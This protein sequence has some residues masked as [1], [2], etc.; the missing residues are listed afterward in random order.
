M[1]EARRLYLRNYRAS[2]KAARRVALQVWREAHREEHNDWARE[3]NRTHAD[4]V[5]ASATKWHEAHPDYRKN[6]RDA[7]RP[8]LAALLAKYRAAKLKATPHWLTREQF[9]Q[10][11][12]FYIE[13]HCLEQADGVKRHVDHIYPLRGK[14]VSG[15]H[16]PWN[17]QILTATDNRHK[18]TKMPV[19]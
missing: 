14:T 6:Y 18:F 1:T 7:H 16:V 17:L 2:H 4:K 5:A 11:E 19:K 9:K 3:W 13:A 15:L 12:K 10:I 8:K